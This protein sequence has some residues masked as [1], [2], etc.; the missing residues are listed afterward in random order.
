MNIRE[1]LKKIIAELDR[2]FKKES[3]GV[4]KCY[5]KLSKDDI[6]TEEE[7]DIRNE[8]LKLEDSSCIHYLEQLS[9]IYDDMKDAKFK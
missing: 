6:S 3:D 2:R 7:S 9:K 8:I 4:E 5:E 1:E